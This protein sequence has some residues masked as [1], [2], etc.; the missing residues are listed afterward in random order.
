[1]NT[2]E[3]LT[4]IDEEI[5]RLLQVKALL[6]PGPIKLIPVKASFK[7]SKKA[8]PTGKRTMSAEGRAR[9]AAAQKARWAKAK[10]A[11]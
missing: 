1:M 11:A 7:P 3:I 10:R 9:I 4:H 2:I 5:A 6:T 8:A